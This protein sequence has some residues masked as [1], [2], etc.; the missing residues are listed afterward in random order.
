M[1][2]REPGATPGAATN[3]SRHFSATQLEELCPDWRSREVYVC[4]PQGLVD[5]VEAHFAAAG[6]ARQVHTE[7]FRARVAERPSVIT[8]GRVRFAKSAVEAPSDG[9][10]SLL[11]LAEDA[12]LN[13]PHGCRMGICHGCDATLKSGCVRDLRTNALLNE[14][15]QLVQICV[16]ASAGDAELDL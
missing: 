12:G 7:R 13:P 4:G 8:A 14:A 16:C 3:A 6:L 2:T 10:V 9:I 15:G 1:F 11:R 5:S